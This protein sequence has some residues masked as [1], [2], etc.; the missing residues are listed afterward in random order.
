MAD[1][2]QHTRLE[3][4]DANGAVLQEN[5]NC[6]DSQQS[7]I[8]ATTIPPSDP[9]ESAMIVTLPPGNYTAVVRGAGETSG[10]G[11]VE[12]YNVP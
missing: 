9:A 3:L 8:G 1:A 6:Q 4:R 12:V 5:D 10:V 2:L 7:E 11:L